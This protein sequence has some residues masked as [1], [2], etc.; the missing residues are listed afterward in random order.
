LA[1]YAQKRY[2]RDQTV[3]ADNPMETSL[4]LIRH[5]E[6]VWNREARM[7]GYQDSPLSELGTAQA[8]ALGR[9]MRPHLFDA[10]YASDALRCVRTARIALD[11]ASAPIETMAELRERSLGD[12]EGLRWPDIVAA[13][14]EGARLYRTSGAYRP[15]NGETFVSLRSRATA[16]LARITRAHPGRRVLIFT[17]GGT[18]R[19]GVF[20]LMEFP[21]DSWA[22][23]SIWNT[24]ITRLLFRDG[25][26]KL[27]G[28]NDVSHLSGTGDGHAMF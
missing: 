3:P 9:R 25:A 12:W 18:I 11:N 23:L 19:A 13:D 2:D 15:P 20:G 27:V 10:V 22:G 5:A 16:A 26:W 28:L 7:Q 14:P 4:L 21:A 6:T 1:D 17:S 24:G 8:E